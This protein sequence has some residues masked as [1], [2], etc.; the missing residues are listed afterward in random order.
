MSVNYEATNI[1]SYEIRNIKIATEKNSDF[2]DKT[3]EYSLKSNKFDPFS[4]SP[5]LFLTKLEFRI[6]NYSLEQEL[7]SDTFTLDSK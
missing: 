2:C 4:N 1:S 3:N 5:N 6:K 7:L